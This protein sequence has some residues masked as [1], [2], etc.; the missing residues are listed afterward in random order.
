ASRARQGV[1][2]KQSCGLFERGDALQERA[3]PYGEYTRHFS[4]IRL[5]KGGLNGS[6]F[7]GAFR[8]EQGQTRTIHR[9]AFGNAKM[10]ERI[11]R[12]DVFFF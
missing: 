12:D 9:T 10:I 11:A 4:A 3:C 5:Q 2:F 6:C 7:F 8:A 1:N